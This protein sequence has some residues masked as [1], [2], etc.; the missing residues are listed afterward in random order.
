MNSYQWFVLIGALMV[1]RGLWGQTVARMPL[2][3]ATIY[4]VIGLLLGPL[5]LNVF[6]FDPL[7]ES[8]FL[9]PV[10]EVAV[11][12]SLFSAG[13][14]M[15]VPFTFARWLPAL[16][17]AWLAMAV[18]V[19]LIAAAGWLLGLPAGAA[20]LLGAILAPTD[21]VLATD[22]QLRHAGDH[23]PL[24]FTLTCEAG[25]NDGSAFPFVMLG[26]GLLGLHE[27][28]PYG[29]SWLMVDVIWASTGGLAIGV[30]CGALL[31][32]ASGSLRKRIAKHEVLDDLLGLGL[33]GLSYGLAVWLHTYGFLAVFAA[34]V[35]LRQ[36]E[37]RLIHAP[38]NRQGLLEPETDRAMAPA[39]V[40]A[41]PT[42]SGGALVFKEHLERL[43]ELTLVLLLGGAATLYLADWR[44]WVLAAFVLFAARPLS[45]LV[46]LAGSGIGR[47]ATAIAAWFGV[48]GIGSIYY[49]TYAINHG[50]PFSMARD[51][52]N[53]ALA[54]IISSIVLH[55]IS[56]SPLL[57]RFWR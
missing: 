44:P 1:A 6:S 37:L 3:S 17:L 40:P 41:E 13:I 21:P 22:V 8:G 52:L 51:L 29:T 10:A 4:L 53:I 55:G 34:G 56:V 19:M 36:T 28:G 32:W 35:A 26:L 23:D 12:I 43:S 18:S 15:P 11:L 33:I 31:A 48:R 45:V 9:E 47:R 7:A 27:L 16:R 42:V 20:I 5:V 14:K 54:V 50:L 30:A 46:S 57:N 25:L 38:T 24:R 49:L 39:V 2:T